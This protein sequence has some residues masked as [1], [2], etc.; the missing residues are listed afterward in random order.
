MYNSP[1]EVLAGHIQHKIHL[2]RRQ[3]QSELYLVEHHTHCVAAGER[4]ERREGRLV[5][6]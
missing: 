5:S 2:H 1:C 4:E 6:G 3:S